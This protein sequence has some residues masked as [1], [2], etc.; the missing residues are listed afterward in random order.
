MNPQNQDVQ[1]NVRNMILRQVNT[2][3]DN[4]P[5]KNDV[6]KEERLRHK[7]HVLK[8]FRH[9]NDDHEIND[10]KI[11][12]EEKKKEAEQK[13]EF[14]FKEV[15]QEKLQLEKEF[16]TLINNMKS[17]VEKDAS[18]CCICAENEVNTAV[19]PCGQEFFCYSCIDD[20]HKKNAVKGCPIC[21]KQ[22]MCVTQIF[23]Q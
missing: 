17:N 5:I 9:E 3:F 18:L 4:M 14:A 7:E 21:R 10:N 6:D 16:I 12:E 20:Y 23:H 13:E 8:L 22:I 1:Y 19:I 2:F 11:K 15:E